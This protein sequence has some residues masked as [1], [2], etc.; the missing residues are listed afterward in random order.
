M[1]NDELTAAKALLT[2]SIKLRIE[3]AELWTKACEYI[4]PRVD[5]DPEIIRDARGK[6]CALENF[7]NP[8][9]VNTPAATVEDIAGSFQKSV[10][11]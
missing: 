9:L 2:S 7:F 1:T 10:K 5:G 3:A 6:Q 4:V 8:V 11:G